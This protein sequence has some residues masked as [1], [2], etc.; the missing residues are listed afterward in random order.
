MTEV[1]RREYAEL[2]CARDARH[3][4]HRERP[5]SAHETADVVADIVDTY[6][7][8]AGRRPRRHLYYRRATGHPRKLGCGQGQEPDNDL[9]HPRTSARGLYG[10]MV[11]LYPDRVNPGG[12]LGLSARAVKP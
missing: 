12:A 1:A 4:N 6:L 11:E 5:G 2:G 7:W 10:K 3:S 8:Q 9:C